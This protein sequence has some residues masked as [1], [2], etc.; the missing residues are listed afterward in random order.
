[1]RML[2]YSHSV[3]LTVSVTTWGSR[4]CLLPLLG[5]LA[6]RLDLL[7]LLLLKHLGTLARLGL[8]ADDPL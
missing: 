2:V 8:D 1:M 4:L 5:N 3:A 7:Q 6:E